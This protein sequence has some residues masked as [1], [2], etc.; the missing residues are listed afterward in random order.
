MPSCREL[1][2][3]LVYTMNPCLGSDASSL[4]GV[5]PGRVLARAWH[6]NENH[7]TEDDAAAPT[8]ATKFSIMSKIEQKC[9]SRYGILSSLRPDPASIWQ[10]RAFPA[11]PRP[12][13]E[14]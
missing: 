4:P 2:K 6:P 9:G 7:I 1:R 3:M 13:R 5:I 8:L 10:L 11:S 14:G 12:P